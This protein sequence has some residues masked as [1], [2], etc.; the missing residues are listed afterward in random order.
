MCLLSLRICA[1]DVSLELKWWKRV[2]KRISCCARDRGEEE[3]EEEERSA[4][5]L[6]RGASGSRSLTSQHTWEKLHWNP[7]L[8]RFWRPLA[9]TVI[10]ICF[11]GFIFIPLKAFEGS[12]A[13]NVNKS[14]TWNTILTKILSIKY[15]IYL[16]YWHPETAVWY[17]DASIAITFAVSYLSYLL[18]SVKYVYRQRDECV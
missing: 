7:A 12:N 3:E 5:N 17:Q 6:T 9:N 10:Y 13:K 1:D 15:Q 16:I 8:Q 14:K 2:R 11:T 18:I 4:E